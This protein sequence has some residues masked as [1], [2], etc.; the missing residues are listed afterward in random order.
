MLTAELNKELII[1]AGLLRDTVTPEVLRLSAAY[2][3]A[4]KS[5]EKIKDVTSETP[6]YVEKSVE[7]MSNDWEKWGEKFS[8]VLSSAMMANQNFFTATF[9]GFKQMLASMAAEIAAKAAIFYLL[10]FISGGKL[11][12]ATTAGEFIFSGFM[13]NGGPVNP[14][15]SYVVGER[16]PEVFT[17]ATAGYIT[18]NSNAV[19]VNINIGGN[20]IS[21][22]RWVRDVLVPEVQSA[23]ARGLA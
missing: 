2:D 9:L 20:V 18:P 13:A 11:S 19:N 1:S 23:A 12:A 14:N 16:G 21:S 4:A 15:E 5:A 7:E 10:D 6:D 3:K 22:R 8:G 17:P